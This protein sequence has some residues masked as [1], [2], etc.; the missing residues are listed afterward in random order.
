MNQNEYDAFRLEEA[1]AAA[2]TV[3]ARD[4]GAADRTLAYGYDVDRNSFHVYAHRGI[5]YV[6]SYNH[7]RE[8]LDT[9]SGPELHA[10]AL[11]PNKRV[12]PQYTDGHFA[13]IMR[14]L[15]FPLSFTPWSEPKR[16]GPYFGWTHLDR[17][18][19]E[20]E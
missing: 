18:P 13:R 2:P 9:I 14:D 3:A 7:R 10:E 19:V 1:K 15:G 11:R 17:S 8:L 5:L 16:E 12:Y 4:V 6:R 20:P